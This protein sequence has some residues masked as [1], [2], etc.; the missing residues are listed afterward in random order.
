MFTDLP[1]I[2]TTKQVCEALGISK[3]TLYS[4]LH[5]QQ[6]IGFKIGDRMWRIKK[7]SIVSYCNSK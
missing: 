6:I 2:L 3:N 1:D 7:E 4:L 5:D